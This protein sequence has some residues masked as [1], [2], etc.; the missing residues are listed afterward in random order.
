[1]RLD[2]QQDIGWLTLSG[3]VTVRGQITQSK[4]MNATGTGTPEMPSFAAIHC[5]EAPTGKR[6]RPQRQR[7]PACLSSECE[8][9]EPG[10]HRV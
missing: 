1:M 2:S 5:S 4:I 10:S 6:G 3:H 8:T 7:T 9:T